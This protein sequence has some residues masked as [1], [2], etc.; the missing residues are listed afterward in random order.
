LTDEWR[1]GPTVFPTGQVKTGKGSEGGVFQFTDVPAPSL[2][3]F[4][5]FFRRGC[6]KCLMG[7]APG[8]REELTLFKPGT[9]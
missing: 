2:P 6:E 4:S 1:R 7:S 8:G 5:F 3:S 9:G